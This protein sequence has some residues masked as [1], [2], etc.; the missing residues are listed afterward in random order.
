MRIPRIALLISIILINFTFQQNQDDPNLFQDCQN[1]EIFQIKCGQILESPE[2][3]CFDVT[4]DDLPAGWKISQN[5]LFL[6]FSCNQYLVP[7]MNNDCGI[8]PTPGGAR[9]VW[10]SQGGTPYCVTFK[11]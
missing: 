1:F 5:N 2:G 9:R 6:E 7:E 10:K 8:C 3:G 11:C 4:Q